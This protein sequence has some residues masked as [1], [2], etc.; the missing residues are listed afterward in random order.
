MKCLA[1]THGSPD[2]G[3]TTFTAERDGVL[4]VVRHV[5][6]LICQTCGEEYLDDSVVDGLYQQVEK[7]VKGNNEV[8]IEEFQA[9]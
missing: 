4:V 3:E 9:A 6:A 1:W 7:A 5:P 8:N 2:P